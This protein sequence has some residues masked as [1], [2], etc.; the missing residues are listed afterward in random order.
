MQ[1]LRLVF[2]TETGHLVSIENLEKKIMVKAEQ[3]MFYYMS[4][5]N[6]VDNDYKSGA[7]I[8]SP[9]GDAVQLPHKNSIKMSILKV[10]YDI[11]LC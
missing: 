5:S 10:I 7:Y 11:M 8:F 9:I 1:Y 6:K 3:A 2:N 4:F